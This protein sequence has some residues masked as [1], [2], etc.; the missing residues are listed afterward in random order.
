M[1]LPTVKTL[2]N[3]FT[4][5]RIFRG[6][7]V[8]LFI[9]PSD[10][11]CI[12]LSKLVCWNVQAHPFIHNKSKHSQLPVWQVQFWLAALLLTTLGMSTSH[13]YAGEWA[14]AANVIDFM[15][16]SG[17]GRTQSWYAPG[18]SHTAV[19]MLW[20]THGPSDDAWANKGPYL[21][22]RTLRKH[23]FIQNILIDGE[24]A[25]ILSKRQLLSFLTVFYSSHICCASVS[26]LS[27]YVVL[28]LSG[29]A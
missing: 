18:Q 3:F 26:T 4:M 10:L 20:S 23:H 21:W 8:P 15:S 29:P 11:I 2:S 24:G 25:D 27:F 22:V 9:T 7:F 6:F 17:R 16:N 13:V 19:H 5:A 14:Q 28:C 1:N 12:L